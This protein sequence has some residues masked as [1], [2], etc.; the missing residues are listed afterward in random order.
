MGHALLPSKMETKSSR[1]DFSTPVLELPG[2]GV[3]PL[4]LLL[5]PAGNIQSLLSHTPMWWAAGTPELPPAPLSRQQRCEY[6][7]AA[8][9]KKSLRQN[10]ERISNARS[11]AMHKFLHAQQL[12]YCLKCSRNTKRNKIDFSSAV[13]RLILAFHV[14]LWL[15]ILFWLYK[16]CVTTR[17]E[18][19][20]DLC[21]QTFPNGT[22]KQSKI[23]NHFSFTEISKIDFH[24]SHMEKA[25]LLL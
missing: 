15:Q 13:C 16:V 11:R 12:I 20:L 22:D 9:S 25:S 14:T 24:E 10:T 18:I 1:A 4:R 17:Q 23:N 5:A 7:W 8:N 6:T 2:D 3:E 21:R 19:N